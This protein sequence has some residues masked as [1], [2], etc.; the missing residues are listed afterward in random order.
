MSNGVL[1][2]VVLSFK[3]GAGEPFLDAMGQM[4]QDTRKHKGFRTIRLDRNE[5]DRDKVILNEV[6]DSAADYRAYLA[7]RESRGESLEGLAELLT[8][9]AQLDIWNL[10]VIEVIGAGA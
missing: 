3:P 9:P 1:V 8:A 2:T 10:P 7:W 4:L 5:N 6:W